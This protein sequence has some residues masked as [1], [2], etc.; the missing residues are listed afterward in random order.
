M[1]IGF[2][3][4]LVAAPMAVVTVGTPAVSWACAPSELNQMGKCCPDGW[5]LDA[6]AGFC[7]QPA[8]TPDDSDPPHAGVHRGALCA[9]NIPIVNWRPCF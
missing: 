1:A 8:A 2:V 3:T 4:A 5:T 7:E 6:R 9:P